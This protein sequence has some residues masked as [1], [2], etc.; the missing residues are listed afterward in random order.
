MI[1]Q[2]V[3]SMTNLS[4]RCAADGCAE[5]ATGA[6][7]GAGPTANG[8]A[9]GAEQTDTPMT[10]PAQQGQAEPQAQQ[11]PH[12]LQMPKAQQEQ[13]L[14]QQQQQQGYEQQQQF[15]LQ[16]QHQSSI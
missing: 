6:T 15:L 12:V 2:P 9:V 1:R 11:T 4:C 3:A 14:T 10:E 7:N 13:M 5:A 8:G 16:R